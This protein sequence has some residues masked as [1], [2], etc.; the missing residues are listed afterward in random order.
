M[1]IRNVL[2]KI[3]PGGARF[4]ALIQIC[5]GAHPVSY[6]MYT[7][8]FLGLNRP[9]RGVDHPPTSGVEVEGTVDVYIRWAFVAYYRMNITLT[10]TSG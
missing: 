2:E 1:T 4:F 9:G 10:F 8:F 6:T 5:P 3:N 7:G